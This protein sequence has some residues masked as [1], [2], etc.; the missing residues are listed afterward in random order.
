MLNPKN[1]LATPPNDTATKKIYTHTYPKRRHLAYRST[2][3]TDYYPTHPKA[4]SR[5]TLRPFGISSRPSYRRLR[6][7]NWRTAKRTSVD[8]VPTPF[9]FRAWSRNRS[10]RT[11]NNL[12][13]R[14]K[15]ARR[16]P[17]C[18]WVA[19]TFSCYLNT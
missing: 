10:A 17:A 18:P 19:S 14:V 1:K 13:I 4:P 15:R 2:D 8:P 7:N 6:P 16:N 5:R 9:R 11:A 12:G 3:S